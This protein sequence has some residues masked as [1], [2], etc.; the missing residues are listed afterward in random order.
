MAAA[1]QL[2]GESAENPETAATCLTGSV[3]RAT[4]CYQVPL[5]PIEKKERLVEKGTSPGLSALWCR[6]CRRSSIFPAIVSTLGPSLC[7]RSQCPG[8]LNVAG[9]V[10]EFANSG[11][12]TNFAARSEGYQPPCGFLC[13]SLKPMSFRFLDIPEAVK[14]C[15]FVLSSDDES[16]LLLDGVDLRTA[17]AVAAVDA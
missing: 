8:S 5:H 12:R 4:L 2:V 16:S 15:T 13:C 9:S 3:Q 7:A 1:L 6:S 11:L 14:C 10:N 17:R